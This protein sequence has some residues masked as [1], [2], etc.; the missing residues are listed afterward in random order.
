MRN[1]HTA[2]INC[3]THT[4]AEVAAQLN[5]STANVV[6]ATRRA[7]ERIARQVLMHETPITPTPEHIGILLQDH[8]FQDAVEHALTLRAKRGQTVTHDDA[9]TP[10]ASG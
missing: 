1:Q 4:A 9:D 5:C 8:G 3:F 2:P 7:M 10:P 6:T